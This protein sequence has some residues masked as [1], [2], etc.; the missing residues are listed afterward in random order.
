MV[1]LREN[2]VK[3]ERLVAR[4]VMVWISGIYQ[5]SLVNE[6]SGLNDLQVPAAG[7]FG[8]NEFGFIVE[9]SGAHGLAVVWSLYRQPLL[10]DS[11][12][13]TVSYMK[14]CCSQPSERRLP[15]LGNY[16]LSDWA[17]VRSLAGFEPRIRHWEGLFKSCRITLG[18][19]IIYLVS[20]PIHF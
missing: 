9:P 7:Q 13:E 18:R 14:G 1:D 20:F 17:F 2:W 19:E 5:R 4:L 15:L 3:Y 12:N 8:W 16:S 6:G 10:L 11:C